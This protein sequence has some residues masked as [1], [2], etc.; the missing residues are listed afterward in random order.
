M[1]HSKHARS[2]FSPRRTAGGARFTWRANTPVAIGLGVGAGFVVTLGLMALLLFTSL[3]YIKAINRELREIVE[4][5][6]VKVSLVH[7]MQNA[8]RERALSMHLLGL[9][10]DPFERD[11]EYMRFVAHAGAYTSAREQLEKLPLSQDEAA[12]LTHV[13]ALTRAIQTRTEQAIE[14]G[15]APHDVELFREIRKQAAPEQRKI[16]AEIEKLASVLE[17]NSQ[18]AYANAS[19]AYRKAYYF[20]VGV[21]L[22]AAIAGV[23][24]A[25]IVVRQVM[26]QAKVLEHQASF[27]SLT[28]LPNRTFFTDQIKRQLDGRFGEMPS[29]FAVLFIDLDR[30][31]DVNDTLGHNVGDLLLKEVARELHASLREG[32]IVARLGGDEFA[33]LLP[34]SERPQAE[35]IARRM[36]QALNQRFVI[37]GSSVD[38]DASI[39]IACFPEHGSTSQLLMQHADVAMYAAKHSNA[40]FTV[41]ESG[42]DQSSRANLALR[43]ELKQAIERGELCLWHQP[44]IDA[45]G[46][47]VGLEALVRWPHPQ[48][49]Y[50]LPAEFIGMAEAN[51]L[52]RPL[53]SWVLRNAARQAAILSQHGYAIPVAINLCARSVQDASLVDEIAQLLQEFALSPERVLIEITEGAVMADQGNAVK[54][55]RRIA[56]LGVR[57]SMD[58]FGTGY[59]S[60]SYLQ[61]LPVAE[62][63]ID[64]SFIT[65][66]LASDNDRVIVRSTIELGHN[67][68]LTVVAEGVENQA[69]WDVL[70][71]LGCDVGQ[72]FHLG[73]PLP[74]GS[75][76]PWLESA[77]VRSETRQAATNKEAKFD[78]AATG[79]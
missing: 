76:L 23:L 10:T 49:G 3:S 70:R 75:L 21:G 4:V 6:N 65:N 59:S 9:M 5:N 62:L 58:D 14:Y 71:Q 67:L 25:I 20:M 68:G 40:G 33:V 13:K 30:F 57:F 61:Q 50:L 63:K 64:K 79:T 53:T 45:K 66:M 78:D 28:G 36:L 55:M 77:G 31:K 11:E 42:L 8:L 29:A 7:T 26:R 32:D 2:K 18:H 35:E 38:V 24:I 16:G 74:E 54:V 52:I 39:G 34:R 37:E 15:M 19:Q 43:S 12:I 41:Y 22:L 17:K 46:N 48:R 51:G 47:V 1:T 56:A 69:V 44:K 73:S 60:L 72:G 27:D